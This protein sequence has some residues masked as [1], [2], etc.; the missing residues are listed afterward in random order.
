MMQWK[1]IKKNPRNMPISGHYPD[2][3]NLLRR[4]GYYQCVYC[5]IHESIFGGFRNYHIEHYKPK[6]IF[7]EL[8]DDYKNLFYACGICNIFKSNDWPN[9]PIDDFSNIS[10]PNPSLTDYSILFQVNYITGEV[11]GQ[12]ISSKY[13]VEKLFLNRPQLIQERKLDYLYNRYKELKEN[14]D[15]QSKALMKK[16]SEGD[17]TAIQYLG[18]IIKNIN[19]IDDLKENLRTT[20]PYET[21]DV[22]R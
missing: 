15:E 13:L 20:I 22:S 11:E 19:R 1:K 2:W 6:S 10:Y 3:R 14:I 7:P 18:K 21:E 9:E 12:F 16:A 17:S 5:S 8:E 4:E